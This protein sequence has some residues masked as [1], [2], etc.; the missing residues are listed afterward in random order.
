MRSVDTNRDPAELA[1]QALA[2]TLG[3]SARAS[4]LLA[5][6]GLTPDDLR[7]RAGEPAV[8]AATLGFLAAHEPDLV[9][10]AAA[11]DVAPEALIAAHRAL[12]A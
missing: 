11:L 4:R 3:D 8:L 6:T 9:G 2:W 10:C 5:L 1:L 7:T 12:E